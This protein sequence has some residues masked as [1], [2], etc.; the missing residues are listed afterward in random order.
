MMVQ[1][2][3]G[4]RGHTTYKWRGQMNH[5]MKTR[6]SLSIIVC[7]TSL[8]AC[9]LDIAHAKAKDRYYFEKQGHVV[10]DV[11][12]QRK[13]IA[14]TFD[15]G[16][17]AK[18]TPQIMELLKENHARATFF[19]IGSRAE[20]LPNII[21]AESLNQNE[22]GNHTFS[23]GKIDH[24]SNSEIGQELRKT[25]EV[26]FAAT[27]T[28]PRLFR[29]PRGFYDERTILAANTAGYHTVMW[30]WDEDSRDWSHVSANTISKSVLNHIHSGDIVLFHDGGGNRART[31]EALKT[32]LPELREEGYTCV[33]VSELMRY[34]EKGN[35][36][37]QLSRNK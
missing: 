28:V 3:K 9:Q 30:S 32:I 34:Q 27:G 4:S 13:W 24:M 33:T 31:V 7:F 11:P 16:P 2:D 29:P 8:T 22:V 18:Y 1:V 17:S 35:L 6:I 23:H 26:V 25:T 14:L 5:L 12:N 36:K 15:D 21:H 10:W 19:V 37:E 20:K